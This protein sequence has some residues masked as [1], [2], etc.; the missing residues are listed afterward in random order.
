MTAVQSSQMPDLSLPWIKK[1]YP[2]NSSS[3]QSTQIQMRVQHNENFPKVVI[4]VITWNGKAD[5]EEC[6]R[7]LN[8]ITYPNYEILVIDNNSNDNTVPAL[9]KQFPFVHIIQNNA[10]VG[11]AEA[12][13]LGVEYART[14]SAKYF[15]SLNN[16]I[17][18]DKDFLTDLVNCAERS[19]K[20]AAVAPKLYNYYHKDRIEYAG[21]KLHFLR[22]KIQAIG[23]GETDKPC[24]NTIKKVTFIPGGAALYRISAWLDIGPLDS[25]LFAYWEDGDW[26]YRANKKGYSCYYIPTSRI[27]HKVS[28]SMGGYK[29][30]TSIYLYS[31]NRIRFILKHA[32]PLKKLFFFTYFF[33]IY[34]PEFI[35]FHLFTLNF[36]A[37][38]SFLRAVFGYGLPSLCSRRF[39]YP[40]F[41][42]PGMHIGINARYLQRRTTGIERYLSELIKN[43]ARGNASSLFSLYFMRHEPITLTTRQ[44]NF[45]SYRTRFPTRNR[46]LRILWEQFWLAIE[47]KRK[48]IDVFHGPSFVAPFFTSCKIIITIHDLAFLTYPESFTLENKL[49]FTVF[50]KHSIKQ[51]SRIIADSHATKKD[52]IQYFHV[53][54]NKIRVIH[55]GVDAIFSRQPDAPEF[56]KTKYSLHQPY[57][58]FAGLITPRK[59]LER[60]LTAFA[61][62][63]S[64]YKTQHI[65]VIVGEKGWLYDSVF[66]LIKKLGIEKDIRYIGHV[67]DEEL[68]FFY[69]AADM[70]TFPSLYE[71]FGLPILEAMACGC[72]VITSKVSSMPEVAGRAALLIDPFSVAEIADAMKSLVFDSELRSK[73]IEAGFKRAK[74]FPWQKTA[75]ATFKVYEECYREK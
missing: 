68:P 48:H 59:N 8:A 52:I 6:L 30:P 35:L 17:T 21:G 5:T 19:P 7:S 72:P 63:K 10:N 61:D 9:R 20:I 1:I 50:L 54:E 38:K 32:T 2:A 31:R 28:A 69:S 49:Y 67:P 62:F 51:A 65:F 46:F 66:A 56:L 22:A 11:F 29:N 12:T 53:P 34:I 71:G 24:Y 41:L 60:I 26:C 39:D 18:V 70:L 45:F 57:I 42:V 14:L 37:I 47:L 73:L 58:L 16:D 44:K 75:E 55:L 23:Y 74:Q 13:N 4:I 43:L 15:F 25:S 64:K 33:S 36:G 3:A 40:A 27:W